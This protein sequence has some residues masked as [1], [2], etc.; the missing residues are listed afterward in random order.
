MR[1]INT[2]SVCPFS[3][4]FIV[5]DTYRTNR[6]RTQVEEGT[7]TVLGIGPAPVELINQVT[8]KLRLL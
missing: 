4:V 1:A 7:L 2:R 3:L 6:G 8:G 5:N